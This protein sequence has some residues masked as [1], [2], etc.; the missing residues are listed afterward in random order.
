MT[1]AGALIVIK[2][3]PL[4]VASYNTNAP[5]ITEVL[6]T[7]S[8]PYFSWMTIPKPKDCIAS[9]MLPCASSTCNTARLPPPAPARIIFLVVPPLIV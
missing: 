8:A 5:C 7:A 9:S 2:F 1:A 4:E 3:K 6:R